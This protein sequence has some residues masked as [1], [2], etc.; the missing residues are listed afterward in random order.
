MQASA[1]A[2]SGASSALKGA[3]LA[4]HLDQ[5]EKYG[6]AGFRELQNGRI[7]YFGELQKAAKQGE[8]AGRRLVREWDPATNAARTWHETLDHAGRVRIVRPEA[9]GP[10][11]H[12]L[13]DESG[14]F[15]GT[16]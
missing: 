6:K 5:L 10:K 15:T 2:A 14:S 7:R 1:R 9:G 11:V 12:Y 8:M 4:R 16:F 3:Q 13:F